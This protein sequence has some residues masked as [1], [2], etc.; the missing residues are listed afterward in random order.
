MCYQKRQGSEKAETKE[1]WHATS[2]GKIA[3]G[4]AIVVLGA[5]LLWVIKQYL[6]INL[7]G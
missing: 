2:F 6:N 4:V 7:Q 3:I 1:A 5:G